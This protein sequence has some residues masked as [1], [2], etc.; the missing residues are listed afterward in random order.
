M[1]EAAPFEFVADEIAGAVDAPRPGG[2]EFEPRSEDMTPN[3]RRMWETSQMRNGGFFENAQNRV[4]RAVA[5]GIQIG[6][7]VGKGV[8]RV[9][10]IA[11][12]GDIGYRAVKDIIG[13]DEHHGSLPSTPT[14][15]NKPPP[16]TGPD[17]PNIYIVYGDQA[18][19][20]WGNIPKYP[21]EPKKYGRRG[22]RSK[23]HHSKKS[24]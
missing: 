11:T 15:P 16:I 9:F 17:Q 19:Q 24:K 18:K 14:D 2:M 21:H 7:T 20:Q 5:R 13:D 23:T 3:E 12:I 22:K 8:D 1:G 10:K 4:G 6:E